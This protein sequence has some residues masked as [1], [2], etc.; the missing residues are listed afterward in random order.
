MTESLYTFKENLAKK[1][2]FLCFNGPIS[3][4]LMVEMGD[5]LKLKMQLQEESIST[6]LKVFSLLIEQTQ[7]IIFYSAETIPEPENTSNNI[8][9][10]IISVGYLNNSYFVQGG[11]KVKNNDVS[12]IEKSLSK[13]Q[14]MSKEE[15]KQF[16]RT[17]RKLISPETSKGAGLGFIEVARKSSKP[18]EYHFKK[19]DDQFSFFSLK[20][21]I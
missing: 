20:T 7:N 21:T 3:H 17:Q 2:V 15:I 9:L 13:L 18:I 19:I 5:I 8:H 14:K 6:I 4:D 1:G 16:Y 12:R 11:N 10:G